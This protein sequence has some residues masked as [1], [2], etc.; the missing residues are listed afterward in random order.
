MEPVV[1]GAMDDGI[2]ASVAALARIV[3]HRFQIEDLTEEK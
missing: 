3:C 2:E 1:N